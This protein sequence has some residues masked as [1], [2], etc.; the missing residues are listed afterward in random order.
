MKFYI[1]KK[2]RHARKFWSY[3]KLQIFTYNP[4]VHNSRHCILLASIGM[5]VAISQRSLITGRGK[6][7]FNV[8]AGNPKKHIAYSAVAIHAGITPP[9]SSRFYPLLLGIIL[10]FNSSAIYFLRF[11]KQQDRRKVFVLFVSCMTI[12][13]L[14]ESLCLVFNNKLFEQR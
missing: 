2:S 14:C 8:L 9:T 12:S 13:H 10:F 11:L 7:Y 1:A 4:S 5:P 3:Q 6:R